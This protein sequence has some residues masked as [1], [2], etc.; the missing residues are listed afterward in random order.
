M[1]KDIY[2]QQFLHFNGNLIRKIDETKTKYKSKMPFVPILSLFGTII[3]AILGWGDDAV[4]I[5]VF[6][7]VIKYFDIKLNS[8][9][10]LINIIYF[11]PT[12]ILMG[13]SLYAVLRAVKSKKSVELDFLKEELQ[14]YK[15]LIKFIKQKYSDKLPCNPETPTFI[16]YYATGGQTKI[17]FIKS[18]FRLY[19]F[20]YLEQFDADYDTSLYL[21]EVIISRRI[22]IDKM[23]DNGNDIYV[24]VISLN[25]AITYQNT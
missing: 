7:D 20:E 3:L 8:S 10:D 16:H 18:D 13:F 14:Q 19:L 2:N 6:A 22:M 17:E 4:G 9:N 23:I 12:L 11:I 5:K 21:A 15:L 25:N 1:N 24:E